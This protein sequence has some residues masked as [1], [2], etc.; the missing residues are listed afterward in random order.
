M[1]LAPGA[2]LGG[3]EIIGLLG[4]GGMGEVYRALDSSLGREVAIK[5]LPEGLAQHPDR[6][7]RFS[8]EARLLASLSHPNIAVVHG[9]E[10]SSDSCYLVMELVR[11]ETLAQRNA[12]GTLQQHDALQIFRQIAE[13]L[14][15]A[16]DQSIIHRDLKPAN[17][18]LT[19]QGMVKILDFG[20]AKIVT[21]DDEVSSTHS[22][23]LSSGPTLAGMVM[24]TA[25][26]MSPE[27]ARGDQVDRRTD[28]WAFGCLLFESVTGHAA[29]PGRTASDTIASVL[30]EEPDWAKAARVPPKLQRLIRRC[31]QKDPHIRLHDIADAR[32]ELDDI[33]REPSATAM[34]S[35][36]IER[37]SLP[38]AR[39]SNRGLM[40]AAAVVLVGL[41]LVAGRAWRPAPASTTVS[42]LAR[43]MLTLPAAQL[44]EKGQ[45]PP[46]AIS[47]NGRLLVYA[48][49]IG[50]GRTKLF[51]RPLDEFAAR[52]L[53]ET[54]G[55]SAPF[56]SPDSRWLAFH[57][58]GLLKKVSV[59]GG[60]PLT[61]GE[62]PPIWSAAWGPGDRIVFATTL[63]KSGLWLVSAN[64]GEPVSITTPA[65]D[66]AQHVYP[67]LLPDGKQVLFSVR[68]PNSWQLALGAVD[69]HEWRILGNGRTIGEGAQYLSTGHIV[70]A[71]SGGLVAT[72]FDPAVGDLNQPPVPLLERL[73]ISRYGGANFAVAADAGTLAYLPGGSSV[74]DRTLVRIERDGRTRPLIDARAAYEYPALS[75]NGR[76]LA[77]MIATETGSDIWILDLERATRTRFTTQG[78]GAFPVWAPDGSKLAFQSTGPF[79]LFWKPTDGTADAQ[80]FLSPFT[81]GAAGSW[82]DAG[83][84]LLPGTLPTLAGA[85]PQFPTTWARDGTLAFHQRKPSG[86]RDIWVVQAGNAAPFIV[87]PFD[88]HSPQFSPDGKWIA[89]VSDESGRTEVFVQ[90]FPGP[91]Q[92]WLLST[93]GGIDPVWSKDGRELFFR[94]GDAL[95]AAPVAPKG[96]VFSAGRPQRLFEVR[97]DTGNNGPNYDVSRDGQW[98][99]VPRQ[100]RMPAPGE[101]HVV[102]NW[103]GE[104]RARSQAEGAR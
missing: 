31:L 62:A 91:G 66:D 26:Y 18:M 95:M 98:F 43:L 70:Y 52:P 67:Q 17:I 25:A 71:Q 49:A 65:E 45:P 104:V 83:A 4:A 42:A 28:I 24:G 97:F 44:L 23:T 48:A 50:G 9:L 103:F 57:A 40:A 63:A 75:P 55:A 96:E 19:P 61:I 79:N 41:G 92:K 102:L 84:S 94:E 1:P 14:E 12:R 81:A 58:D 29:F 34:E 36:A 82:P 101:L 90:P 93:G 27:Q 47:P 100:D 85:G 80:P 46:L 78:V 21:S 86:E 53:P 56:F 69:S 11:G 77:M 6:L 8:R 7:A 68:R 39:G 59:A 10:R 15:A 37:A 3:Y 30:K 64:G 20:L 51:L 5:V 87:T 74:A 38:T 54:D 72:A 33:A 60:V 88:E 89:Y 22:S 76:E 16:H 73:E 35:G 32:I 99:V 2:R 13:G